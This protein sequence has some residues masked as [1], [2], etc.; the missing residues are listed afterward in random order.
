MATS[1]RSP[2]KELDSEIHSDNEADL[3]ELTHN[4]EALVHTTGGD[5]ADRRTTTKNDMDTKLSKIILTK[6]S[7]QGT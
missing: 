4:D 3:Q 2:S 6:M 5:F 1:E 7:N